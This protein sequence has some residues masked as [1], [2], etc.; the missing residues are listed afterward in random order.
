MQVSEIWVPDGKKQGRV[1]K[2]AWRRYAAIQNRHAML[3]NTNNPIREGRPPHEYP[4]CV[5]GTRVSSADAIAERRSRLTA[6]LAVGGPSGPIRLCRTPVLLWPPCGGI[7]L[8]PDKRSRRW[9]PPHDGRLG[10][11]ERI[12]QSATP[13]DWRQTSRLWTV[14]G[15]VRVAGSSGPTGAMTAGR[16]PGRSEGGQDVRLSVPATLV[17]PMTGQCQ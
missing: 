17:R 14:S 3:C 6:S 13:A 11:A 4:A 5:Q 16:R 7:H 10:V 15:W 12:R 8:A 1:R 9:I 2:P